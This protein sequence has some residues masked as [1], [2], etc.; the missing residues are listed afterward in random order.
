M[1]LRKWWLAG[2]VVAALGSNGPAFAQQ[3]PATEPDF[4]RGRISGYLFG[5][6]YYN[7]TGDPVHTY[8]GPVPLGAASV[9]AR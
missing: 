8:S 5:D 3:V 7:V 4:P 1:K 2:A 9:A 6:L